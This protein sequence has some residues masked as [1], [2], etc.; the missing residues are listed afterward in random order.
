MTKDELVE[1]VAQKAQDHMEQHHG[2]VLAASQWDAFAR[3]TIPI[4]QAE[5]RERDAGIA[6]ALRQCVDTLTRHHQWHAAQT[7]PD[8][9]YGFIPADEYCDSAL[10]EQTVV[11]LSAANP[12]LAGGP[13][14]ATAIRKGAE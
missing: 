1:R 8:P 10:Y 11:A 14:N 3:A 5:Q 9:E 7:A 13:I 12:H 2:I 4:V 6:R